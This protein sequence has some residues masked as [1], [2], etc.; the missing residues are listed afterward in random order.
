MLSS[1]AWQDMLLGHAHSAAIIH[2]A[3]VHNYTTTQNV[4]DSPIHVQH[5]QY[6]CAHSKMVPC[7]LL[8]SQHYR[9][10][11]LLSSLPPPP[12]PL[13]S[14]SLLSTLLSS[15]SFPSHLPRPPYPSS[16]SSSLVLSPSVL[17]SSYFLFLQVHR[18]W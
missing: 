1:S 9:D 7:P 14:S 13:M 10:L 8:I 16:S 2:L 15:I 4:A 3:P 6:K 11:P 17:S 18:L 12:P 5:M